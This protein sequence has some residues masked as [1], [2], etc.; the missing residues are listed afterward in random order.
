MIDLEK[1][2][3]SELKVVLQFTNPTVAPL[4]VN[5]TNLVALVTALGKDETT[6]PGRIITFRAAE[7]YPLSI[8]TVTRT[9]VIPMK[10]CDPHD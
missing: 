6:W 2:R 1:Y 4:V 9:A 10:G 3:G 7:A 5:Y 8:G